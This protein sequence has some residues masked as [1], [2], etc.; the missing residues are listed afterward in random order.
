MIKKSCTESESEIGSVRAGG[1]LLSADMGLK[2][3]DTF[4]LTSPQIG[5][6]T[7]NALT[8]PKGMGL[9]SATQ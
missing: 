4:L 5:L 6:C 9:G 1:A 3:S 7:G 2:K 8:L